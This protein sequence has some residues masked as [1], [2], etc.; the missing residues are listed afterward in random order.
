M[1]IVSR[2]GVEYYSRDGLEYHQTKLLELLKIVSDVCFNNDI[3]FWIDG[4]TLLGLVRHGKIIPWDDD[5]DICLPIHDYE[6]LIVKLRELSLSNNDL[7]L[8]YDEQGL[9]SWSE[10]LGFKNAA[11]EYKWGGIKPIRIDLLPI[12]EISFDNLN[13][14]EK[15]VFK[16]ST[17]FY[18]KSWSKFDFKSKSDAISYKNKALKEYNEYMSCNAKVEG[19][20][21]LV[22]GHGQFS[23]IKR[24]RKGLV[25]P[26]VKDN[27]CGIDVYVPHQ[28]FKYLEQS[29]GKDYM[30][31]PPLDNRRPMAYAAYPLEGSFDL[32]TKFIHFDYGRFFY[33]NHLF[34]MMDFF[35]FSLKTLSFSRFYSVI[36]RN[37]TCK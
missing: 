32:M 14:D 17:L 13:L 5:I 11:C 29:Y 33:R 23:P 12:K 30:D 18:G 10:Y 2:D 25:Y 15:K 7:T 35:T 31:L 22:K 27:F 26:L 19:D 1:K 6:K 24:V 21:Y 37:F 36:K 16:I 9:C 8:L 3:K 34:S 20:C 28:R 4:G